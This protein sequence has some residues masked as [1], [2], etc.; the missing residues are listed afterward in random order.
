MDAAWDVRGRVSLRT[1]TVDGG[2]DIEDDQV[3]VGPMGVEPLRADERIGMGSRDRRGHC[4]AEQDRSA[5]TAQA[6]T[7]ANKCFHDTGSW[8]EKPR[9]AAVDCP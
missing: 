2:T 9:N 5:E 8:V 4:G 3:L 1:T 7:E 6:R